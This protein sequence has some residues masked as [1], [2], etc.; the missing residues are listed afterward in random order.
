[1]Q[2]EDTMLHPSVVGSRRGEFGGSSYWDETPHR[3]RS[4]EEPSGA[5]VT[6]T[7]YDTE[8]E[9][10]TDERAWE[11]PELEQLLFHEVAASP[12]LEKDE[13]R[14]LTQKTKGAWQGLLASLKEHCSR[15]SCLPDNLETAINFESCRERD[16]L[17]LLNRLQGRLK[18]QTRGA[19]GEDP[20]QDLRAFLCRVHEQLAGFRACRDELVRRNLRLVASVA[21]HYQGWKLAYLDLVQEGTFGLM[22]AIEKFDPDKE[23]RFSTYAI[24]WIWQAMSWAQDHRGGEVVRIPA[25]LHTQQRRLVRLAQTGERN[26]NQT[27]GQDRHLGISVV[28][29]DA[30]LGEGDDRRLEEVLSHPER[31]SPE[32]EILKEDSETKLL[33]ALTRL[34]PREAEIL[35][36]RFGLEGRQVLTLEQVGER[37]GM[38]RERVRQIEGK[39]RS[40]LRRICQEDGLGAG[41]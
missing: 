3:E 28:S 19:E 11:P 25:F 14:E 16:V 29:L 8:N 41:A 33:K 37:L 20:T 22:R 23:V 31:L 36:L 10:E 18:R 32:E 5:A 35:R 39:A 34:A 21:R 26:D 24:W 7:W 6:L 15:L 2:G 12:L 4:Q 30:P 9:G 38:S 17:Q 13:E 40:R 1:M 27:F